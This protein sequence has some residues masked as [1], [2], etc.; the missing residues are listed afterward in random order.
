MFFSIIIVSGLIANN[1]SITEKNHAEVG[2]ASIKQNNGNVIIDIYSINQVPIAG[3]QFEIQP[4]NLFSIDSIS[5]GISAVC[6]IIVA[7]AP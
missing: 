4:N 1:N 2:I 5:G 7:A 6:A 3:F